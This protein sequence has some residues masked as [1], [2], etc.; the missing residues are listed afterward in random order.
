M[1]VKK[2]AWIALS[3]IIVV[4]LIVVYVILTYEEKA[5]YSKQEIEAIQIEYYTYGY[6]D[7]INEITD[8]RL[9]D[10]LHPDPSMFE[11]L[12]R[13]KVTTE[14]RYENSKL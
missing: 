7:A 8:Q 5:L 12:D 1:K 6:R 10:S 11:I 4:I 13:A 9:P 3:A 14:S 2:D